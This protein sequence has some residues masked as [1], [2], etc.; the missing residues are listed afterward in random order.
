M[1]IGCLGPAG[2]YSELA[3]AKLSPSSEIVLFKNF[4][5][6]VDALKTG[7]V[8]EIALPI[9]NTIQGGVLQNMDLLAEERDLFA[10]KEYILPVE[11]R[12][13]HRAG[14][15]LADIRRIYSHPQALGQCSVFLSEKLPQAQAVPVESTAE[16]LARV[17]DESDACI[18]GAH[19]CEGLSARGLE[20]YRGDIADEKKNFTY[21]ELV[22]KGEEWL[23]H[24]TEHVYFVAKLLHRPGSLYRLL[25]VINSYGLN[26]TKI[27]SRPIKDAPGDYRFFIEVEGNYLAPETERALADMR[28]ICQDFKLLGC[29]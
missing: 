13:V 23:N 3:A 16:G 22:K 1:K 25:G 26:M 8:D 17:R 7:Q 14:A 12:L 29:Y 9:E 28:K 6:V 10:V 15:S 27:E 21:F 2:S 18:V 24:P 5:A 19:L 11:H 4:P 20:V